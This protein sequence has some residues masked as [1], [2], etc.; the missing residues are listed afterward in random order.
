MADETRNNYI[1]ET[2]KDTIDF[3]KAN[4]GFMTTESSKKV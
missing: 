2:K 4:L 1:C 3:S